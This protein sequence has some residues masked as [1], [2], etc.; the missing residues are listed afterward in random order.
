MSYKINDT[1]IIAGK[2]LGVIKNLE[3]KD[4]NGELVYITEGGLVGG[5]ELLRY[6][7]LLEGMEECP[8]K[9]LHYVWEDEIIGVY[10]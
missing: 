4:I 8:P 5:V 2:G 9:Q 3:C 10:K 6:G 7:T 1:A